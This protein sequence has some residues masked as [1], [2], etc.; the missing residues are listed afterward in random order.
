MKKFNKN[1][2][3]IVL[4]I[5]FMFSLTG[6]NVVH[7]AG[8]LPVPLLTAGSFAVLSESGITN[9]SP[10][11]ITGNVGSEPITGFATKPTC[12]EVTGI[13]YDRDGAYAGGAGCLQTNQPLLNQARLDMEAAYTYATT[14]PVVTETGRA[15]GIIGGE[16][17]VPGTYHWTT[18]VTMASSITLTGGPNDV[19]IFQIDGTFDTGVSTT[20]G[21]AGGAQARNVYWA[22]AGATTLGAT[23]TFNGTIIEGGT[24]LALNSGAVVNG[25]LLSEFEVTLSANTITVPTT[26]TLI[27]LV[28]GIP[29]TLWTLSTVSP[30]PTIISGV[31]GSVAV[32]NAMVL[33][34]SYTLSESVLPAGYTA[35]LYSCATNG[36]PAVV[37]NTIN[38]VSGDDV[39]CTITNTAMPILTLEK[40]VVG[41]S[42][43]ATD[44][45]LTATGPFP[46]ITTISGIIGAPAVTGAFVA[47]G[48]YD[49]TETTQ[50]RYT[51]GLWTCDSGV[52][53]GNTITLANGDDVTCTIRNT[54]HAP[55]SGSSGGSYVLP[56]FLPSINI[57]STPVVVAPI[58]PKLPKTGFPPQEKSAMLPVVILSGLSLVSIFLYFAQKKQTT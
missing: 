4:S 38:L 54:Y 32:T 53:V 3:G 39:I 8:P 9:I 58:I 43:P 23:S 55:S 18:N 30:S 14:V 2:I 47:V 13:V 1:L 31:T 12:A 51:G 25:R 33:P 36:L 40:T 6:A 16:N 50:S 7:A 15:A 21:L 57:I 44:F 37:G 46:L 35:G 10:S 26:L 27:K 20:V 11:D 19:W 5:M 48:S 42:R 49:L 22:V 34:G 28:A 29:S 24:P 56:A 52:L 17:F 45:T 41:G